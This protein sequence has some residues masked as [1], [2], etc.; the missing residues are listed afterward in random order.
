MTAS[1]FIRNSGLIAS[2]SD[3]AADMGQGSWRSLVLRG[4]RA[5]KYKGVVGGIAPHCVTVA[6]AGLT[7]I[8]ASVLAL[9]GGLLSSTA[10]F[11]GAC[12]SG[13]ASVCAGPAAPGTDAEQTITSSGGDLTI[14]TDPGFGLDVTAGYGIIIDAAG[15]G[16]LRFIDDN[17]SSIRASG[18]ALDIN[19]SILAGAVEV[20]STGELVGE[21]IYGLYLGAGQDVTSTT[22]DVNRVESENYIGMWV[23]N[24][25]GALSIQSSDSIIGGSNSGSHD[26]L[27]ISN[28]STATGGIRVDV[29][30]VSGTASGINVDQGGAGDVSVIARGTVTGAAANGISIDNGPGGGAVDVNVVD[31]TGSNYGIEVSNNG[32]GDTSITAT[33]TVTGTAWTGSRSRTG[34]RLAH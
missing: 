32:V 28:S 16:D 29:V 11:A 18:R 25:G 15:T 10:A 1:N 6:S 31:V 20:R 30:D 7:V 4:G 34:R 24:Y 22:L 3:R 2:S 23:E 8:A 19:A 13:P 21:G 5:T 33:G 9:G 27:W 17:N 26:G 12:T 14:T